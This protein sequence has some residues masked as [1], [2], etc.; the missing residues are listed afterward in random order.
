MGIG[1]RVGWGVQNQTLLHEEFG[2]Y[3]SPISYFISKKLFKIHSTWGRVTWGL[4]PIGNFAIS[5]RVR[6]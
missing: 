2:D 1:V 5:I 3:F 6:I 4:K